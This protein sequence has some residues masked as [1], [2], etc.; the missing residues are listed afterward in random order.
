MIKHIHSFGF[1]VKDQDAAL[2]F[3]VNKLGWEKRI[4]NMVGEDMRFLTVAPP[5]GQCEISLEVPG[6]D[7][8][9]KVS[10]RTTSLICDDTDVTFKELSAKGV[11]FDMEPE[12]NPWGGRGA[13]FEDPDGNGFFVTTA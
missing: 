12:D 3:Y 1:L 11:T 4:D 7:L 9:G 8:G 2:D 10:P 6:E 5:G 13:H